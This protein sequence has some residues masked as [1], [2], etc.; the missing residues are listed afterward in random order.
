MM[1]KNR[2]K[3]KSSKSI[4]SMIDSLDFLCM[5]NSMFTMKF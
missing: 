1:K 3:M 4:L 5:D 2:R